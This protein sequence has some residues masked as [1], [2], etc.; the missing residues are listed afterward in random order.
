M[1]LSAFIRANRA[2]I[3]RHIMSEMNAGRRNPIQPAVLDDDTRE[4]WIDND[5]Y[6]YLWATSE[7]CFEGEVQEAA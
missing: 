2:E 6:L 3:D 7:G 1:T 5:E 4:D